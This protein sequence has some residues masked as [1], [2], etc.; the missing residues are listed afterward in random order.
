MIVLAGDIGGTNTRLQ[1]IEFTEGDKANT[2]KDAHLSN[3]DYSSFNDLLDDFFSGTS[4]KIDRVCFDAAGPIINEAIQLTN[5][6]WKVST[7]DIKRRFK[8]AKVALLNDFVAIGYG[9]ETLQQKDLLTLQP[10]KLREDG[11]KAYIGA[12]TGLGVGFMTHIEGSYKVYPTEGGHVDFAPTNNIQDDLLKFMQKKYHRVSIE[13]VLSGPGLMDIY[14]FV[15]SQQ[16]FSGKENSNLTVLLDSDKDNIDAAAAIVEY[17][18]KHEDALAKRALNIFIHIYGT[19]VGNLALTTLP[20]GGLYVVGGI[21]PKIL[22]QIKEEGFL[23]AFHDKGRMSDLVKDIP[24]HIVLC[25]EVGLQGAT[26][27]AKNFL[28]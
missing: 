11:V 26:L 20:F 23:E 7:A 3:G 22:L 17:A 15:R 16:E 18:T 21:A 2:L 12:G 9:L 8:L 1:L 27:Y 10:G 4:F 13:R 19:A 6:S 5:L 24:L 14:S 25:P 28:I